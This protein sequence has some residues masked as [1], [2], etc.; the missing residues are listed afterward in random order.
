MGNFQIQD[1]LAHKL[2]RIRIFVVKTNI[3]SSDSSTGANIKVLFMPR[4]KQRPKPDGLG[5]FTKNVLYKPYYWQGNFLSTGKRYVD[6][7]RRKC[8]RFLIPKKKKINK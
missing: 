3:Y 2:R 7:R 8:F 5:T 6:E 1:L 4:I